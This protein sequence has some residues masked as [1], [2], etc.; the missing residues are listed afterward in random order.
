MFQDLV[1]E[2]YRK[3]IEIIEK[4]EYDIYLMDRTASDTV[5]FT[6]INIVDKLQLKYLKNKLKKEKKINAKHKIFIECSAEVCYE[7]KNGRNREGEMVSLEYLE[8][9]CKKYKELASKLYPNHFVFNT[10][11][12]KLEDYKQEFEKMFSN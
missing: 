11:N 10:E 9:L 1:I 4:D 12:V 6:E 7:R 3:D 2:E 5:I 8:K